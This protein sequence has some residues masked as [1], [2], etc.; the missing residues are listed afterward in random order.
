MWPF[1]GIGKFARRTFATPIYRTK[2]V[3]EF[4]SCFFFCLCCLHKFLLHS[5]PKTKNYIITTCNFR[6]FE[7]W[8]YLPFVFGSEFAWNI[9][10]FKYH[11]QSSML[12]FPKFG[13]HWMLKNIFCRSGLISGQITFCLTTRNLRKWNGHSWISNHYVSNRNETL[14]SPQDD[15][16]F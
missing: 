16:Q 6:I 9:A 1:F 11:R 5:E 13:K 3:A 8:F 14:T 2:M 12:K 10:H 7:S 15:R 4:H